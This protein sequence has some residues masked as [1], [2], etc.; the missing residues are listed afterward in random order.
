MIS[1]F[2]EIKQIA[3][4]KGRYHIG[5][6]NHPSS[7]SKAVQ[8]KTEKIFRRSYFAT[9]GRMAEFLLVIET[10]IPPTDEM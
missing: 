4:C 8:R 9:L 1:S 7:V 2:A 5:F 10:G 3:L 6:S